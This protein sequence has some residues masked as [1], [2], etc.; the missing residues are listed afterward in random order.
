[1]P[2]SFPGSPSVTKGA[3]VSFDLFNPIPQ[4][5]QFQ[6]NPDTLT[7]SLQG[8]SEGSG[9]STSETFRLSGPPVET[10]SLDIEFD[11]TDKLE[12]P[13]ENEMVKDMGVFPQLSALEMMLYPKSPLVIANTVL[14]AMGTMEVVPPEGPFTLFIWGAKRVVPVKL[15][16][17]NITEEAHDTSLNPIRAKVQLGMKVLTYNDL[18]ITHPGYAVF[19]AHQV[20]K[21]T[22]SIIGTVNSLEAIGEG[23]KI[24]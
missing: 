10:I 8:Q 6:Y 9:G 18:S 14:A 21:E 15:T 13:D 17:F 24:L 3:I 1:M 11:A 16:Q 20:V 19:L 12:H 2:S 4:V 5:V 23:V 7:R 22:M